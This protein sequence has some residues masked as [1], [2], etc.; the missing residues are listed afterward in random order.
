[1]AFTEAKRYFTLIARTTTVPSLNGHSYSITRNGTCI[2]QLVL[3]WCIQSYI[4]ANNARSDFSFDVFSIIASAFEFLI[5]NVND[6]SFATQVL[7][8]PTNSGNNQSE[9]ITQIL[10]H[11]LVLIVLLITSS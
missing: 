3:R 11:M 4:Y 2:K 10:S 5:R 7:L 1:M 8:K 6:Y 9:L